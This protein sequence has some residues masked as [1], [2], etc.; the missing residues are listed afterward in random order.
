MILETDLK[1]KQLQC[2]QANG[3]HDNEDK[4]CNDSFT[5]WPMEMLL[6]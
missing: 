3:R 5:N 2:C 1:W 4:F 6:L